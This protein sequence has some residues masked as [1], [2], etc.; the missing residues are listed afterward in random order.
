[1]LGIQEPKSEAKRQGEAAN[2][3]GWRSAIEKPSTW[4]AGEAPNYKLQ[5]IEPT[6]LRKDSLSLVLMVLSLLLLLR[7]MLSN[8]S[9][10]SVVSR[11]PCL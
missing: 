7:C 10:M 2:M 1:M 4:R 8:M 9:N 6:W 11:L 5:R 3:E